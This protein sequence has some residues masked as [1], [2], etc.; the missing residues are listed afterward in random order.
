MINKLFK[1]RFFLIGIQFFTLFVFVLIIYG[2]IGITTDDKS[3]AKILRNT[4]LSN[5]LIWSYWWPMIIVTA[6][7]FGRFWCTICPME[8]VTSF[9]SMFGFK[10]KPGLILKSGWII[11][12]FY[13][14]ILI[15]GIHTL[16]IHR[17]PQYMAIYMLILFSIAVISGVIWEK[18]TFCT[19]VCPVGHLLGLYSMLSTKQLRVKNTEV[20]KT[21]KTKDCI[22]KTNHY[23]VTAR[24]C[25]SNLYPAE[26]TDN[27]SCIVC[28]QCHKSCTKDNISIQK[29]KIALDLFTDIKLSWAEISFFMMLSSFVI[30][31][32][33]SEWTFTKNILMI[34]PKWTNG[35]LGLQGNFSGTIKAVI[36]FVIFPFIFYTFFAV[37]KKIFAGEKL[38]SAFTQ[39]VIVILPITASMHLL[40]AL[41]KTTS[42]I[43]YWEHVWSDVK[44]VETARRIMEDSSYLNK[45]VLLQIAPIISVLSILLPVGALFLSIMIIR[46]Q[47]NIS[48]LSKGFSFVAT[49][50]YFSLF[51]IALLAWRYF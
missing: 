1:K 14:M 8:L 29:R 38:K 40:K 21:C 30:Y 3:F 18:R 23:N 17:I 48:N 25:T 39:L 28:G 20:C 35:I 16:A 34:V 24:S 5:L 26:L 31:E 11:S 33:L 27:R 45:D 49:F 22:S 41:L 7:L 44:G 10:R 46:K 13:A 4:N 32:I 12:L 9:F 19:Y 2:A 51:L 47:K 42:R 50:I 37:L 6:I 43:P 15:L 36:L